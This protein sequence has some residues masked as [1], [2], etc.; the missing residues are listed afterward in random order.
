MKRKFQLFVGVALRL[1]AVTALP[2][3]VPAGCSRPST[4]ADADVLA[5]LEAPRTEAQQATTIDL[6]R[7]LYLRNSCHNCHGLDG[8]VGNGAPQLRNLYTTPANLTDG[9]ILD[10]DRDYVVRSILRPAEEIVV[11]H[12]QQMT[13]GYR[14]LPADEVAAIILYLEQFSP[15]TTQAPPIKTTPNSAGEHDSPIKP[16]P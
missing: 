3:L 1:A 10:R 7:R 6:G 8:K 2:W 12:A 4:T 9:T 14:F 11:G 5:I 13:S 15:P 16:A